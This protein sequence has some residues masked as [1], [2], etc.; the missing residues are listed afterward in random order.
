MH[1]M[2]KKIAPF[3][4]ALENIL[5]SF[6]G[7]TPPSVV[8]FILQFKKY[9]AAVVTTKCAAGGEIT[10]NT[11]AHSDSSNVRLAYFL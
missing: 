5:S 8:I 10:K 1:L 9:F 11:S 4:N 7:K 2:V 6:K 3:E